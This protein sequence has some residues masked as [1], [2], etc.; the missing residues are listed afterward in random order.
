MTIDELAREAGVTT[1]TIRAYQT[2]GLL[3]HPK[4]SGRVGV[5]DEGHLGRLRYI[6]RLQSEGFSLAGI[7]CL[8]DAWEARRSLG[9]VL[10]FEDALTAPW[11]DEVAATVS[12]EEL[13][14]LFPEVADDPTL[15]SRA[16]EA[17]LLE[18]DGDSWRVPSP[19]LLDVGAELVAAGIPLTAVLDEHHLLVRDLARVADRFVALF[20]RHV[21]DPFVAQGMAPARL[22]EVTA[23]LMRVRPLAARSVDAVLA[24]AMEDAVN[25]S[26]ARQLARLTAAAAVA[27]PADV[28]EDRRAR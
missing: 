14:R 18:R 23:A 22:A 28:A 6:A 12:T 8:L 1:R 7:R 24:R 25:A 17:G 21:W 19:E 20:E 2:D 16:V 11:S 3:P 5:Y 26:M 9:D 15:A 10:G 4:L 27:G 13:V